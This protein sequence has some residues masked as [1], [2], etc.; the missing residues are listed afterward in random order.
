MKIY[1]LDFIRNFS[2]YLI[3]S[4]WKLNF[5]DT[6]I[7]VKND[8]WWCS[9]SLEFFLGNFLISE[10]NFLERSPRK[11]SHISEM[12]IN[13]IT[14]FKNLTYEYYLKQPKSMLER[15]MNSIF[16]KNLELTRIFAEDSTH[17]MIRK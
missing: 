13:F 8:K 6:I 5:F 15:K 11:F 9:N 17:P 14:D 3:F 12:N 10:N 4:K 1:I 2:F 7:G 16:A